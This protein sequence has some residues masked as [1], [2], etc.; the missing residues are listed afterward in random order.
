MKPK[1]ALVI[2]VILIVVGMSMSIV[3]FALTHK[4]PR[5]EAVETIDFN[6]GDEVDYGVDYDGYFNVPSWADYAR[7]V[8]LDKGEYELWYEEWL[9]IW[10]LF[11]LDDVTIMGPNGEVD[12]QRSS[13][14]FSVNGEDFK[15]YGSFDIDESDEYLFIVDREITLYITEPLHVAEGK[16]VIIIGILV[17]LVGLIFISLGAYGKY[18]EKQK[19]MPSP[20]LP[21]YGPPGYYTYPPP[22]YGGGYPGYPPY[23][24]PAGPPPQGPPPE[25]A[26]P[27]GPPS[28]RPPRGRPPEF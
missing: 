16:A 14:E 1:K 18:K 23:G 27:R 3:A 11:D 9:D 24:P 4:D 26:P 2:G 22:A 20:P 28:G 8:D 21:A 12:I 6:S 17:L 25:G 13:S 10:G 5:N 19:D 15:L 7:V